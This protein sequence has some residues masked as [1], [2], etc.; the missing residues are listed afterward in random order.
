[1]TKGHTTGISF[2]EHRVVTYLWKGLDETSDLNILKGLLTTKVRGYWPPKG[3][4]IRI[5]NRMIFIA[6]HMSDS[7]SRL[8]K[9]DVK[10]NI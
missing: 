9:V 4:R 2:L 6:S 1:M 10:K 3:I 7:V 5:R 8:H